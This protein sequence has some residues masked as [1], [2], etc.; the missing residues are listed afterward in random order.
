MGI[1]YLFCW[2]V[3]VFFWLICLIINVV[4]YVVMGMLIVMVILLSKIVINFCVNIFELMMCL[5]EY[6]NLKN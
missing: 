4:I 3:R 6:F 5:N 2:F 1:F